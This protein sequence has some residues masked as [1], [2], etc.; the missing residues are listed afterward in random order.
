MDISFSINGQTIT[1][2]DK[3]NVVSGSKN[4]LFAAFIFSDD[5]AGLI[6]TAQF[7]RDDIV[8]DMLL[9]NDRC[10]VPWELLQRGGAVYVTVFGGDLIT[11]NSAAVHI[12]QSGYS[13]ANTPAILPTPSYYAQVI[14]ALGKPG[15]A[16]PQ[17]VQGPQGEPGEQGIDG[18]DGSAVPID[19]ASTA[20]DR[21]WSASKINDV[22][23]KHNAIITNTNDQSLINGTTTVKF[24]SAE[25]DT[26][27]MFDILN[28]TRLTIKTAGIY[29]IHGQ[30]EIEANITGIRLLIIKLNGLTDIGKFMIASPSGTVN[31]RTF[32]STIANLT[33]NDYIEFLVFQ[34]SGNT[35]T[36]YSLS[37]F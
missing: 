30:I 24:N 5:W 17:G 6:K 9:V 10:A 27:N 13:T 21:V 35:L 36:G 20:N 2:T 14:Q 29:L 32:L 26:N 19:D 33:V 1:R 8:M 11:V 23:F 31:T 3:N 37:G 18:I 15:P 7:T 22:T 12:A 34:N 25:Q 4:Y 28:D 16:G